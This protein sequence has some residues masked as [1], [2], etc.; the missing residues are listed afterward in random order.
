MTMIKVVVFD[1]YGTLMTSQEGLESKD[2]ALSRI[3]LEAGHD[4]YFQEVWSARQ[5]VAFIDYPRGRADTPH[6]YY[7]K[8]LERLEIPSDHRLADK[9]AREDSRIEKN[10]LYSDVAPTIDAL[11]IKGV[12]TAIVTT[13]ASW[14]FVPLLKENKVEIDFVCTAREAKAVKPNPKA[15]LAVLDRF[16]VTAEESMMVGDDPKTD[17]VP[18]KA[19]GMKTVLICRDKKVECKE[20]EY[21]ISSLIDLL[22]L[23]WTDKS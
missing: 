13:I 5:F 20:A 22:E 9:L 8:V 1:L 12:K 10:L 3:L 19:L 16:Q 14:R 6:Q 7:A 15:C 17:I 11:K 23:L 2:E 18:A 21:T 4:V